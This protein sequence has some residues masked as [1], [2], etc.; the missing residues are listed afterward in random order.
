[1]FLRIKQAVRGL[2]HGVLQKV[3]AKALT[4]A[5]SEQIRKLLTEQGLGA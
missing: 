4:C 1:M 5:D 3:V 2:R